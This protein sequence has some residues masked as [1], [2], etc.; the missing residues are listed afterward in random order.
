M[1]LL[2][3]GAKLWTGL[4][5]M[6]ACFRTALVHSFR[7]GG[8]TR[9]ATRNALPLHKHTVSWP[10]PTGLTAA[11]PT[12]S[13]PPLSPRLYST[14]SSLP[15]SNEFSEVA[16]PPSADAD[17]SALSKARAPFSTPRN[18]PNDA[19]VDTQTQQDGDNTTASWKRLGLWPQVVDCLQQEMQ[20]AA[21]TRVQQLVLPRLLHNEASSLA[22]FA[23]TGSGKT[24]AYLL[25]LLQTLKQYDG[26]DFVQQQIIDRRPQRPR[27]LVLA[28]TR[29][30]AAQILTVTKQLCHA[31][32]LSSCG[33]YGGQDYA[34]QKRALKKPVD[35]VV[36]TPGRLLKHW[37]QQNVFLGHLEAVVLD[38]MDTM[39]EQGFQSDLRQILYPILYHKT[40]KIDP[41]KDW[42]GSP[43]IILTS[44]TLT[45]AIQKLIGDNDQVVTAKKNYRNLNAT[46]TSRDRADEPTV[47]LPQV[48]TLK[49]PGLHKAVPRLQ[50]N[51]ID[52]GSTDKL[53]L[54]I[55]IVSQ[56]G[57]GDA[58]RNRGGRSSNALTLI[59][60]NTAASCR[61]VQYALA[62]A[63]IETLAYHGEL[64][65]A[66]RAENL[67]LFRNGPTGEDS[68]KSRILVCTDL[69]ARGLDVPQVDHVVMFDFPLNALDYLHRSGRTARGLSQ[70]G[71]GG[72]VTAL[73]GK[74]DK[75]LA[76]AIQIA[77]QR[78]EPLDGLS[79]RKSDYLPGGRLSELQAK[80][81]RRGSKKIQQGRITQKGAPYKSTS[82]K[83]S[84]RGKPHSHAKK[85]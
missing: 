16:S 27:F 50:H 60:C 69:A 64:N 66:V 71:E 53:S 67:R 58:I 2:C 25:P 8:I 72:R 51:F 42:N 74:R 6:S 76:N 1:E 52:V 47:L 28:P 63:T 36:A 62:E 78:G 3:R 61:A 55:D 46:T 15:E 49:A 41:D 32:K 4:V 35:V 22:F 38:E 40:S 57:S 39:L 19:A 17:S 82:R 37:R 48:P 10:S 31:L 9:S 68:D 81:V 24:L 79:S 33:V 30:L 20:L 11:L 26:F 14:R 59:F 13:A 7:L 83:A 75:V 44:A 73:V 34:T 23:A 18:A 56:G 65:S 77:V 54:L 70:Q 21:P 84:D 80:Q 45:K 85:R 29:E 12:S 43:R 5:V